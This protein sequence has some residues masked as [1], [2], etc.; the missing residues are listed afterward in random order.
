MALNLARSSSGAKRSPAGDG[1]AGRRPRCSCSRLPREIREWDRREGSVIRRLTDPAVQT[2]QLREIKVGHHVG[3][4]ARINARRLGKDL[5]NCP[6]LFDYSRKR[7]GEC[8]L[9]RTIFMLIHDLK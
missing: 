7:R 6:I 8:N 2:T 4:V 5:Y 1:G 9:E 3:Q